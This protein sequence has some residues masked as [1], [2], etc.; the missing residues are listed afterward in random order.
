[1]NRIGVVFHLDHAKPHTYLQSPQKL[2]RSGWNV[3]PQLMCSPSKDPLDFH[4]FS[5]LQNYFNGYDFDNEK[6]IKRHSELYFIS[7][8][9]FSNYPKI[10]Q[11]VV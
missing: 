6:T 2:L 7:K 8:G 3:L 5:S 4:L 9:E 11:K 10:L 1:M